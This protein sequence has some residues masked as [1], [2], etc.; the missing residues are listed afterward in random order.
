MRILVIPDIHLKTWIFD[1]ADDIMKA[2]KADRAVCLMDIPDD[3]DM[4]FQIE[5]YREAYDRA[6][7]FSKAYPD[8]LWCYGNHDVSYPWGKLETGY[9]PYA[10]RI[11][12]SKLEELENG[13]K[14]PTQMAIMH[15]IDN[16]LF[17]HGGLSSRFVNRLNGKLSDADIDEVIAAVNNAP[18]D[19]LWNDESPL[20]L[21]PQGRKMNIFRNN[22][23]KQVVGHTP[24]EKIYEENGVISTDVF[25]TYRDGRQIGES[26]MIVIESETGEYEKIDVPGNPD[27]K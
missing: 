24:V 25:S 2:G 5:L 27:R 16:V 12:M 13:L 22:I 6:I 18:V 21:R 20:W 7:E 11:V 4:Q 8:T 26:A 9:S 14:D 23:Y 19:V 17:T 15:R 3:W 1:R 10:E